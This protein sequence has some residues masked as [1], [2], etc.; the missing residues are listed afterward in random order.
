MFTFLKMRCLEHSLALVNVVASLCRSDEGSEWNLPTS[1][2]DGI[3][4]KDGK[5]EHCGFAP[6]LTESKAYVRIS[7]RIQ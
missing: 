3:H 2:R 7:Q 5:S 4:A 6:S 1:Y